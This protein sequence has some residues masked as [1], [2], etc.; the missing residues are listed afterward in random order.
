MS[1]SSTPSIPPT[2]VLSSPS[3]KSESQSPLH[4]EILGI[5]NDVKNKKTTTKIRGEVIRV[6]KDWTADIKTTKGD[7]QIKLKD[8]TQ[9]NTSKIKEGQRVEITIPSEYSSENSNPARNNNIDT[10]APNTAELRITAEPK[11]ARNLDTQTIKQTNEFIPKNKVPD[12]LPTS[13][14]EISSRLDGST[15]RIEPLP[16]KTPLLPITKEEIAATL[17]F[18]VSTNDDT[19]AINS[20]LSAGQTPN[21]QPQAPITQS[22]QHLKPHESTQLTSLSIYKTPSGIENFNLQEIPQAP[23]ASNNTAINFTNLIQSQNTPNT[24]DVLTTQISENLNKANLYSPPKT[25]ISFYSNSTVKISNG[26]ADGEIRETKQP[27]QFQVLLSQPATVT[28]KTENETEIEQNSSQA[29]SRNIFLSAITDANTEKIVNTENAS[30]LSSSSP[31]LSGSIIGQTETKLPILQANWPPALSGQQFALH[32]SSNSIVEHSQLTI[33]PL[34][35][36][37]SSTAATTVT[38]ASSSISIT[39]FNASAFMTLEPWSTLN[40]I[41]DLVTNAAQAA[42]STQNLN[43][44]VPNAITPSQMTPAAL[45]IMAA[46][47]AGDLSN[48]LNDK[49]L[50]ILKKDARGQSLLSRLGA[51]SSALSKLSSDQPTQD[52]RS[53]ILPLS[54]HNEIHKIALHYKQGYNNDDSEQSKSGRTRFI[55]DLN[56]DRMG[57]VQLDGIIQDKRLDLAIRTQQS[58]SK[59]MRNSMRQAYISA[60]D[61][62]GLFGELLFQYA[63]ESWVTITPNQEDFFETEI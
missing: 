61:E 45:F 59:A 34:A 16:Q 43:A 44:I 20:Q 5:P 55:F 37:S 58:L 7:V 33:Q 3:Y 39:P 27:T 56:L 49:S 26:L 9:Q 10:R 38:T 62:I 50:E 14:R 60:L 21:T 15:I 57:K 35:Q 6:S 11:Q 4:V 13:S 48:I 18:I 32:I 17:D 25:A 47:R 12:T 28:L 46:I 31:I 53:M 36:N 30:A 23:L 8:N 2:P 22:F 29:I 24:L 51:E 1:E 52:L 40:S 42:A 63:P 54:H 19:N 41:N